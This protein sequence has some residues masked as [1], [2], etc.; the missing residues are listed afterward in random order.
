MY[1]KAWYEAHRDKINEKRRM[2]HAEESDEVNEK[3]RQDYASPCIIGMRYCVSS[4]RTAKNARCVTSPF[5]AVTCRSTSPPGTHV[6][7]FT[8]VSFFV[9]K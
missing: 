3:R 7:D 1:N 6:R 5:D 8:A 9:L 4:E 2:R